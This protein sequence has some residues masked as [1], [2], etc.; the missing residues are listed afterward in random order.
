MTARDLFYFLRDQY[1]GWSDERE[2]DLADRLHIPLDSRFDALSRGEAAKVMLAAALAPAPPW[3]VLDEPFAR[4]APPVCDDVLKVF[5][6]EAPCPG[7]SVLVATHDLELAARIADRVLV[8]EQGRLIADRT[9]EDLCDATSTPASL[10]DRLRELYRSGR[11]RDRSV[12]RE[13]VTL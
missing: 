12:Q 1:P 5:L 3:L 2:Q 7:G 9:I 10:P 13:S 4:L 11:R 8:M 6:E